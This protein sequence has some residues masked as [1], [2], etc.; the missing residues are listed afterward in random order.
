M[1]WKNVLPNST[2]RQA[3]C[4]AAKYLVRGY[5]QAEARRNE[6]LARFAQINW[7]SSPRPR[8]LY[9]LTPTPELS[10]IGDQA[11]AIAIHAWL[12]KH[13]PGHSVVE[14]DKDVVIACIDKIKTE[15]KPEDLIF[16]HS[17]GNLGDR[18]LWSETA[19]RLMIGEFQANRI[20][21][22]PQ[23]IHFSDTR[24]GRWHRN[25][26]QEIY[27]KHK[28]L[29]IIGRDGE[30]GRLA[31]MLFPEAQTLTLPDFVLSLDTDDF[32]LQIDPQHAGKTL[33]CLRVDD[34]SIFSPSEREDISAATG[35][36]TTL[37]DTTISSPIK[38]EDR[39]SVLRE[40]LTL[41]KSHSAVVTDRYHGLIFAVLCEKPTV[42]LPTVDHKLTSAID[43]FKDIAN[44]EFCR[45]V[46]EVPAA[47]ER[48]KGVETTDYPNFNALYFDNLSAMLADP[49][50]K[51]DYM[52]V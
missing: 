16:L 6:A 49:F 2:R 36:P 41:F 46:A 44:V 18:G 29:T 14:L 27:S 8:I 50:R 3:Q 37:Y 23:T 12:R 20:V 51:A 38:P 35:T 40:A 9:A 10:N 42:V 32:D 45:N 11:Q 34:E 28:Q 33:A 5:R 31:S 4:F 25:R 15:T 19:R 1:S 48:V 7:L 22:L 26:S 13:Y 52:F 47:L 24:S 39:I 43:W 17:G 30:S 21:S